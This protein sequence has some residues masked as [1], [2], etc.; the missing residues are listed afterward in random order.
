MVERNG[1]K[2]L[3][4][5]L[6]KRNYCDGTT[7]ESLDVRLTNLCDN[8]CSFC[9]AAEGMKH[10][11]SF[12]LEAMLT[13]VKVVRPSTLSILGGEPLL[14]LEKLLEFIERVKTEVPEVENF[15]VTTSLPYTVV[16][17]KEL[18]EELMTHLE[19]LNVS[20]QH[21]RSSVNNGILRAKNKFDRVALLEEILQ[22]EDNRRKVRVHLNLVRG[23]ID[24][25]EELNGVLWRLR[26]MG[27]RE[28]KLNE[29][30][31]A[32]EDYVSFEDITG[33]SLPSPYSYGCS[34]KI[35]FFPGLD[36]T[37]KRSCFVVE[38]SRAATELD[39]L[40]VRAKKELPELVQ[41]F[42]RVLYEDGELA[43]R[44]LE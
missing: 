16:R 2:S 31:N 26:E 10:A 3:P 24:S 9:I 41:P 27:V 11:R 43:E 22:S 32:P 30:M 6:Q 13:S 20:V 28:I 39:L 40:K 38:P 17:Q 21:T 4:L 1:R 34:T 5:V 8:A 33:Q 12:D 35:D 42:P 23:G 14:F 44:W 37:L 19:G 15:H 25:S 36:I 29:L 18:F 7:P